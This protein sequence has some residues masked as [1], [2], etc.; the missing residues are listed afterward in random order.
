MTRTR[1]YATEQACRDILDSIEA[2][3]LKT[4]Q[5]AV[6]RQETVEAAF[7]LME[8]VLVALLRRQIT[9]QDA[10]HLREC[11]ARDIW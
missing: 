4:T 3:L 11:I 7:E 5:Q 2:H 10:E 9:E 6:S 8:S 1:T